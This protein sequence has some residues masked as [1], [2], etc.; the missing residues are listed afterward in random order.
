M[1]EQRFNLLQPND[2]QPPS[3]VRWC[4]GLDWLLRLSRKA[5]CFVLCLLGLQSNLGAKPVKHKDV[6]LKER[7]QPGF[8]DDQVR[9]CLKYAFGSE[10]TKSLRLV[11]VA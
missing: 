3:T 10:P 2:H 4:E 1:G 5:G 9:Y 11:T 6:L 7:L 8:G